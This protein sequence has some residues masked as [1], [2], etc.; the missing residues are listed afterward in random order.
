MSEFQSRPRP[1]QLDLGSGWRRR[2]VEGSELV[3]RAAQKTVEQAENVIAAARV[4]YYE[5]SGAPFTIAQLT[6]KAGISQ[7]TFY[8]YFRSK[9][10]LL[11]ALL[12]EYLRDL[13]ARARADC[14]RLADPLD[15]LTAAIRWPFGY[16]ADAGNV[17]YRGLITHEHLRLSIEYPEGVRS[18]TLP[19]QQLLCDFIL[20]AVAQGELPAAAGAE[21]G[22][23]AS[24]IT[25]LMTTQVH[26]ITLGLDQ[27]DPA[28]MAESLVRFC[29]VGIGASWP[30][31]PGGPGASGGLG[32]S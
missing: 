2:A 15:R 28:E 8:R 11:L 14:E 10:E 16:I 17:A 13:S 26:S 22:R 18:A 7:Q 19:Q 31:L 27:T 5:T 25:G 23:L 29:F 20:A 6:E 12:E 9:D 4:L 21:C 24:Y 32:V 1:I 30:R 3:Q